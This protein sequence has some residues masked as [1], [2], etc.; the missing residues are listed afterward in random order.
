MKKVTRI[1][2]E[3][4]NGVRTGREIATGHA[5]RSERDGQFAT[6]SYEEGDKGMCR[7]R[8]GGQ[9]TTGFLS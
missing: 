6:G 8:Q 2:A 4:D 7:T 3:R 9:N 5:S 1:C